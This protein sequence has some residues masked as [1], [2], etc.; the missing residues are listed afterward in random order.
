MRLLW[1]GLIVLFSATGA[2]AQATGYVRE[3]GFAGN[4]RPDCWVP[5]LVHLDSTVSQPGEYQ[6]QVHQQDLDQDTVVFTRT[7]TLG[8]NA[9]ENFWVYF[10]PQPTDG[11]LPGQGAVAQLGDVLKVHL[12][13]KAGKQHVATLP[14]QAKANNVDPGGAGALGGGRG[15]KVVLVVLEQ[16]SYH[17]QEYANAQGVTEDVLFVPVRTDALPDHV[18]G[19]QSVDAVL[20]LDAKF[21]AIRNTPQFTALQAWVRQGGQ[22]AVCQPTDRSQLDALADAD[23]LPVV[24]K[25]G[26]GAD[27]AWAIQIRTKKDLQHLVDVAQ[28]S[29]APFSDAA[30]R[31]VEQA[32]AGG[33]EVAFAEPRPDAMVDAWVEWYADAP[34]P[35]SAP[36]EAKD[37]NSAA[38]GSGATGGPDGAGD[39]P[40]PKVVV[41]RSPLIARRAYGL[42]AVSWVAQDLGSPALNGAPE[43]K[44]PA[45]SV[46]ANG[47][48]PAVGGPPAPC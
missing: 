27:A 26:P 37:A 44:K 28:D 4:Y 23:M 2:M 19:Y 10:L 14:V 43:P 20:W 18:L 7:V 31:A 9:R 1:A 11:G 47:P 22:L 30:W 41:E 8:P 48:A 13:D 24:A 39:A 6:V 34:P 42:G 36:A 33:F 45:Q 38:G 15:A 16:G 32:Q 21:G 3:L 35:G 5:L 25:A 29:A 46:A 17:A 40:T 12:Y